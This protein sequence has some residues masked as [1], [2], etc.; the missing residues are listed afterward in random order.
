[1]QACRLEELRGLEGAAREVLVDRGLGAT[2][3]SALH[4][5]TADERV[6]RVGEDRDCAAVPG[7]RQLCEGPREEVD[8]SGPR[9]F[10]AVRG[11]DRGASASQ[12]GAVDQVVVDEA[13]HVHELDR[14]SR[15]KRIL[16][17]VGSQ[18]NEEGPETLA[19]RGERF[20]PDLG[21]EALACRDGP[22]EAFLE[23]VQVRVEARCRA[24]G[25][26]RAHF[27]APVCSATIPPPNR[28]QRM[29][30]KPA[31]SISLASPCGS[32]NRRTLAGRYV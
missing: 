30:S 27:A 20:R 15:G 21:D 31:S 4:D 10:G 14:H 6:G 19:A 25:C 29:S 17:R 23:L 5:L 8:A 16:I 22:G 7:R 13:R 32:G 11:P 24:D 18:E 28:R 12:L 1:M 3:L 9:R 2:A 26:D